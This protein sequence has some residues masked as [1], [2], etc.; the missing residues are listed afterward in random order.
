MT[1][2]DAP[3]YDAA[4][5]RRNQTILI[6]AVSGFFVLL[7][8]SWLLAGRPV[9]WPW[10][11]WIHFRARS[12]A[13]AFLKAVEQN[14]Q[15]KAYAIWEGSMASEPRNPYPFSRFEQD[16]APNS[17]GNEYGTIHSHQIVAARV[18]GNVLVMGIRINGLQS[19]EL[20]LDYDPKF[21]SLGF[22]PVEL[23]LGP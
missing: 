19:E 13:N 14:D 5:E 8:A 22:S 17:S 23:Y 15:Q 7:V 3:K 1:L 9:D 4:R 12:T 6:A 16:W 21:K 10:N 2:L 20:F 11:W 18:S